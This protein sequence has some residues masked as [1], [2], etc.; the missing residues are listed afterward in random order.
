MEERNISP[1]P[2]RP[3]ASHVAAPQRLCVEFRWWP[4]NTEVLLIENIE[5]TPHV[6]DRF[7]TA[8][9]TMGVVGRIKN[10]Q[11]EAFD[12]QFYFELLEELAPP[13]IIAGEFGH[14]HPYWMARR[15]RRARRERRMAREGIT[16]Q[17]MAEAKP[18]RQGEA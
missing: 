11:P 15:A 16:E 1:A 8:A 6:K 5:G 13:P 10:D 18:P 7:Y 12:A 3:D 17:D 2:S 9:K 4:Q 14:L